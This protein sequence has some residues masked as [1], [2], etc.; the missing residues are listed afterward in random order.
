[1]RTAET[2]VLILI[3]WPPATAA[4]TREALD[5]GE[6][7]KGN[8]DEARELAKGL[9]G[10]LLSRQGKGSKGEEGMRLGYA[11]FGALLQD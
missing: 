11:N 10:I 2:N 7:E 8:T 3:S 4:G 9:A 1:M 5:L 6:V